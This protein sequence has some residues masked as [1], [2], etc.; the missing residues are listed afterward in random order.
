MEAGS[1]RLVGIAFGR[2][3]VLPD[4]REVLVDGRPG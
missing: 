4:R 1:E 3:Q 2:F